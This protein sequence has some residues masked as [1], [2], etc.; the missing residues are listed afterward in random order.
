MSEGLSKTS[1]QIE[2]NCGSLLNTYTNVNYYNHN[3]IYVASINPSSI[4]DLSNYALYFSLNDVNEI[5]IFGKGIRPSFYNLVYYDEINNKYELH[6]PDFSVEVYNYNQARSGTDKYV[7]DNRKLD[8]YIE[9]YLNTNVIRVCDKIG[10]YFE[11]LSSNN[12]YPKY[13]YNKNNNTRN[14]ITYFNNS[15]NSSAVF[16]SY[17]ALF[18]PKRSFFGRQIVQST[19]TASTPAL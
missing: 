1:K 3:F 4:E 7:Y 19:S 8:T 14:T 17:S 2:L 6:K 12:K 11:Y 5:N 9:Y 16:I 10:N 15:S 13:Y 18:S